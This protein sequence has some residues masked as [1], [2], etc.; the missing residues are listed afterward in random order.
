MVT[1]VCQNNVTLVSGEVQLRRDVIES[2]GSRGRWKNGRVLCAGAD[3]WRGVD[4][5]SKLCRPSR[6]QYGK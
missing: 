4:E 1:V 5:V 6:V 3:W 2:C